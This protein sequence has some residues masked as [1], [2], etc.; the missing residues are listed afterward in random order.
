VLFRSINFSSELHHAPIQKAI[1]SSAFTTYDSSNVL[2]TAYLEEVFNSSTGVD[3]IAITNPGYNYT[4]TP[5]VTITG[6]GTGANAVA[7][8]VNGK[9]ST[10]TVTK[11]GVDYTSALVTITGGGGQGATASAVVQAKYGTMRLY[12][13]NT[14]AEKV[15]IN[16]AIG[17]IDYLNGVLLIKDLKVVQCLSTTND[18]RISAQPESAIIETKQNQLLL[19]DQNDSTAI[20]IT[21]I[22]R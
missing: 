16:S 1:R 12:Y 10:I 13:F 7:T 18:L 8:V 9:I 19:L 11:R 14:N 4:D 15:D 3:S 6:D 17:T 21:V 20:S 5:N 2:R 22:L